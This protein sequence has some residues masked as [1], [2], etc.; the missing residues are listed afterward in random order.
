MF[1]LGSGKHWETHLVCEISPCRE[2]RPQ[3]GTGSTKLKAMA[4]VP[5]TL[6]F[7]NAG[8]G[9]NV[10]LEAHNPV[11][12]RCSAIERTSVFPVSWRVGC[13][14][15]L[16]FSVQQS[17]T[18]VEWVLLHVQLGAQDR[19]APMHQVVTFFFFFFI[20]T[21]RFKSCKLCSLADL[22]SISKMSNYIV[23]FC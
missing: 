2:W 14:N 16:L 21:H 17:V 22:K 23:C 7:W 3:V 19:N 20:Q 8:C 15:Y 10:A 13:C 5:F 6:D 1:S 11:P 12:G 4:A 18:Q 9:N